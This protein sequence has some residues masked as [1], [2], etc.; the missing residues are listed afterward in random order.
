MAKLKGLLPCSADHLPSCIPHL[1]S[2]PFGSQ[3]KIGTSSRGKSLMCMFPYI[4]NPFFRYI[5]LATILDSSPMGHPS[6]SAC[7]C[8][9]LIIIDP[10]PRRWKSEC[11]QRFWSFHISE[12][13][14]K[15]CID[16]VR[17]MS[18]RS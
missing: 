5:G 10:I 7:S 13:A 3:M 12:T 11:T 17:K 4:R 9:H 15:S 6:F 2:I 16:S 8:P 1:P 14:L 18:R